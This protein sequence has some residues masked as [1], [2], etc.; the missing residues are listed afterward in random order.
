MISIQDLAVSKS[1]QVICSVPQLGIEAGER[2]VVTG[3]NGS[4][5]STLLRVIAGLELEFS[6]RL[7]VN[8]SASDTTYVH[9]KPYLFRGTVRDNLEYGRKARGTLRQSLDRVQ[10]LM[11]QLGIADLASSNAG[12]LSGGEARRVAIARAL[13]F[14]PKLLL[15][16]EPTADLDSAGVDGLRQLL[17]EQTGMTIVFASPQPLPA[18]FASRDFPICQP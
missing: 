4:G 17:A 11:D 12:S 13:A 10:Q 5:K 7:E 1:E 2:V 16:D 14:S 3:H 8:A 18:G 6:G 9:Q 15:L